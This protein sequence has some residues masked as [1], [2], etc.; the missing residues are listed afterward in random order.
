MD[1]TP[2]YTVTGAITMRVVAED[3][4][5]AKHA[6]IQRVIELQDLAPGKIII[7]VS[8]DDVAEAVRP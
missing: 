5:S 1:E 2:I 3:L 8:V 4:D 7:S 6:F